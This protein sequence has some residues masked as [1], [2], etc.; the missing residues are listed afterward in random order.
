MD[1]EF[2]ALRAQWPFSELLH[3]EDAPLQGG[4]G[5]PGL[6]PATWWGA[7]EE[8][9]RLL[10]AALDRTD[11]MALIANAD[12]T[13]AY[14]NPAF[15]SASGHA[16]A[17]DLGTSLRLLDACGH[18]AALFPRIWETI[19]RGQMWRGRVLIQKNDAGT[20]AGDAAVAPLRSA[21]GAITHGIFLIRDMSGPPQLTENLLRMQAAESISLLL[22]GFIHNC[23]NVLGAMMGYGELLKASIA[24]APPD[25][26]EYLQK[27][28]H[29]SEQ[30]RA[31]LL[32]ITWLKTGA[33]AAIN[34]NTLGLLVKE[35]VRMIQPLLPARIRM[36]TELSGDFDAPAA[37]EQAMRKLVVNLC[38]YVWQAMDSKG[39]NLIIHGD[40]L[41]L[42]GAT[43]LEWAE[44]KPGPYLRLTAM[45]GASP[46][47]PV[48]ALADACDPY[49]PSFQMTFFAIEQAARGMGGAV[50]LRSGPDQGTALEILLPKPAAS[51]EFMFD[52]ATMQALR[53]NGRILLAGDDTAALDLINQTLLPLGYHIGPCRTLEQTHENLSKK[54]VRCD[55]LIAALAKLSKHNI[56]SVLKIRAAM[57]DTRIIICAQAYEAA[58]EEAALQKGINGFVRQVENPYEIATLVQRVLNATT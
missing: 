45:G 43:G 58:Q 13:I 3:G 50:A 15:A 27:M 47:S 29:C 21:A 54:P 22:S 56:E 12:A 11:E 32:A 57:P 39:G 1:N 48:N 41:E 19:Q 10:M 52:P 34:T 42:S 4:E 9:R 14:M 16:P 40:A 26:A 25:A 53:G 44:L 33:H 46:A 51:Q 17:K 38:L 23:N 49:S 28:L 2:D 37:D 24:S 6:P 18:D 8:K 36:H 35:T 20:L 7:S 30:C 31:M 5:P 55:L